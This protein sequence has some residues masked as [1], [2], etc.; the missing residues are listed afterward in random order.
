LLTKK[1]TREGHSQPVAQMRDLLLE[2]FNTVEVREQKLMH[3]GQGDTN[4]AVQELLLL[5]EV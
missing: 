1:W 4:K 3:S 5:C 2:Y